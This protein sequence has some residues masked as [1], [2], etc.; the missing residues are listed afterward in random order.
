MSGPGRRMTHGALRPLSSFEA[1]ARGVETA[2]PKANKALMDGVKGEVMSGESEAPAY[3]L[4][5]LFPYQSYFSDA[6]GPFAI[7]AQP[8]NQAIVPSTQPDKPVQVAG[9]ALGLHPSSETPVAV[10]FFTGAQQ[11][12]SATYR[13]KPGEIIRPHGRPKG[14]GFSGQFS[15]FTYGLPFGWLGGGS[16]LLVVFRTADATANWIDH[17][18]IVFHR[19]RLPIYTPAELP[20]LVPLDLNWPTRFPWPNAISKKAATA[21]ITQ[22][23][24]PALAMNP[25]RTLMRL[26]LGTI[27]DAAGA[28]MRVYFRI[29]DV[30]AQTNGEFSLDAND[31]AFTDYTWGS[32]APQ[33]GAPAPYATANEMT[34]MTGELER[35]ACNDGAIVLGSTH[36]ELIGQFVDFVRY[37]RL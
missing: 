12:A 33:A 1:Y 36:A 3:E 10:Q 18:E 6:L 26:R 30:L 9:Y 13:L 29:A 15:G 20:A 31:T 2:S 16:A 17:N 34:F 27:A 14:I 8:A 5:L 28:S 11:G 37:G 4:P 35:L 32:Y 21:G 7:A 22:R 23:G 25:T 24:Q 19:V